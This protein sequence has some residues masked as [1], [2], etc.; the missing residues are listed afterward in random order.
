MDKKEIITLKEQ[1]DKKADEIIAQMSLEEKI[2]LMGGNIR[3]LRLFSECYNQNP[4]P[5][6]SNDRLGI[7]PR[8]LAIL[9][10]SQV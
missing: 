6:G 3:L 8:K 7:P 4:Y 1:Y 2:D 9:S 5:A 10:N